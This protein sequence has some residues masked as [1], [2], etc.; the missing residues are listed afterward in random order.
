[1]TTSQFQPPVPLNATSLIDSA[2]HAVNNAS[3]A[4]PSR[5]AIHRAISTAYYAVFHAI[6]ASNADIQHGIPTDQTKAQAWT[7]TYRRMRH[8]SA[9]RSLRQCLFPLTQDARLLA[10]SFMNLKVARETADY[11]PNRTMTAAEAHY[12]TG[13]ARARP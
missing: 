10:N 8:N 11:D 5:E 12:W 6:N 9:A 2:D 4:G 13:Q 1:M 3:H 7:N